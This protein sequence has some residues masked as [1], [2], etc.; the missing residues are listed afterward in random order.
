VLKPV[1]GERQTQIRKLIQ[2]VNSEAN[3]VRVEKTWLQLIASKHTNMC[4]HLI[5]VGQLGYLDV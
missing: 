4:K 5:A 1:V 2:K 3:S